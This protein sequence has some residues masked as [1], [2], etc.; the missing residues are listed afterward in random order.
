M[1]KWKKPKPDV[2]DA[3]VQMAATSEEVRAKLK[4]FKGKSHNQMMADKIKRGDPIPDMW[5]KSPIK[6]EL[7]TDTDIEESDFDKYSQ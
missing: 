4:Q 1:N 7:L 3:Q 6:D 5:L 2:W